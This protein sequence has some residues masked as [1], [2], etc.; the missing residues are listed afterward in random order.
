MASAWREDYSATS[1]AGLPLTGA[2]FGAQ[3]ATVDLSVHRIV[4]MKVHVTD[5][6]GVDYADVSFSFPGD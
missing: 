3:H 6:F 2:S 5:S 1:Q 4:R